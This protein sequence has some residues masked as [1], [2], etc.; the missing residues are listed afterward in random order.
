MEYTR[1]AV[2]KR[3]ILGIMIFISTFCLV[4]CGDVRDLKFEN[5]NYDKMIQ[6]VNKTG[7]LTVEE[8]RL[9]IAYIE[10]T[11]LKKE[12]LE[13]KTVN[14][15]IAEQKDWEARKIA[16]QI[17]DSKKHDKEAF[18]KV[19]Q[20]IK[21]RKFA[22][23]KEVLD[24]LEWVAGMSDSEASYPERNVFYRKIETA[25]DEEAER[26]AKSP[27][28]KAE[29]RKKEKEAQRVA[30]AARHE[31][32]NNFPIEVGHCEAWNMSGDACADELIK[33]GYTPAEILANCMFSDC[34]NEL[35]KAAR[36]DLE[37]GKGR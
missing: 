17:S 33:K 8:G 1:S 11:K 25:K 20:L 9:F 31:R 28:G 30:D 2:I 21:E 19:E 27:A 6:K 10:R 35:V 37:M 18:T 24:N 26:Y 22:K 5:N 3:G 4:S 15:V 29:A 36:R 12:V 34:D 14:Q 32:S 7:G 13:G 23:A 16:Q